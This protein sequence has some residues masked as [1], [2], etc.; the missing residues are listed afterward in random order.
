MQ[1]VTVKRSETTFRSII[2]AFGKRADLAIQLGV[3]P[4]TVRLWHLRDSIP[5]DHWP[6]VVRVA[7]RS[8]VSGVTLKLLASLP[9]GAAIPQPTGDDDGR[10]TR[11]D[12]TETGR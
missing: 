1:I 2:K 3:M 9:R 12:E 4:T 8:G 6:R 7:R 5:S 11:D 10:T